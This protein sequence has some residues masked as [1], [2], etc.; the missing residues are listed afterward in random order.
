MKRFSILILKITILSTIAI[1]NETDSIYRAGLDEFRNGSYETAYHK[2]QTAANNGHAAAQY[3][4]ALCYKS[5]K[6]VALNDSVALHFSF[7][8]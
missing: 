5:G 3:N 6:G 1:A 8:S 7:S 4:L 2:F